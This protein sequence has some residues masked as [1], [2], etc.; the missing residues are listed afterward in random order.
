[1]PKFPGYEI[2]MRIRNNV[3]ITESGN[4]VVLTRK[5]GLC[6]KQIHVNGE[7]KLQVVNI[8]QILYFFPMLLDRGNGN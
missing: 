4:L 7:K 8:N 6:E 3:S 2:L 1:M 5:T